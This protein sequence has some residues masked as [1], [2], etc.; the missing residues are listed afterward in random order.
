MGRI[1][2]SIIGKKFGRLTVLDLDHV[3]ERGRTYWLCECECGKNTIVERGNLRYGHTTSCGCK[4]SEIED[5]VGQKFGRL[6][7]I[8]FD[9]SDSRHESY[10]LCECSCENKTLVCASRTH[11]LTGNTVSCGCYRSDNMRERSTTHGMSSTRLYHIW[12]HMRHRC[13]DKNDDAYD[14][15]GGRGIAVSNE[16]EIF[17]NFRDWALSNGYS[18]ELSID[19]RDNN[20][21]Y[22]SD[23]CRWAD[24][25]TQANNTRK[26]RY[27]SY[28]GETH[29]IS[30]WSRIL[31][32][33]YNT[34][35]YRVKH[36]NM[37]DFE[38]YFDE[39]H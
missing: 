3:T 10:W 32:V 31:G 37:R 6:T 11:L 35:F 34:L 38:Q 13:N 21:N 4:R 19:R 2:Y 24:S 26:N 7:V 16:W 23:N 27:I 33:N 18:D 12:E 39:T 29:T 8:K 28:G 14:R 9:H 20:G 1:D 17:E 22:T 5:L 30:E 25:F 36:N 15:Y